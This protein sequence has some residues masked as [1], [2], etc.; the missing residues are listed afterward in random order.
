MFPSHLV[1]GLPSYVF[2]ES[3]KGINRRRRTK[4]EEKEMTT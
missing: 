3:F 2:Q 4:E 1:Y